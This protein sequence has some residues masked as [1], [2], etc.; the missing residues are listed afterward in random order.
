[1]GRKVGYLFKN[2]SDL[3]NTKKANRIT[4]GIN[5]AGA[6]VP[7]IRGKRTA[8]AKVVSLVADTDGKQ[9]ICVEVVPDATTGDYAVPTGTAWNFDTDNLSN[10][11]T[12]TNVLS[13]V[14]LAVDEVVEVEAYIDKSEDFQWLAKKQ[15][16]GTTTVYIE[17]TATTNISTYTGTIFDNPIDRTSVEVGV[18]VRSLKQS[19]GTIPNSAAG[20]GEWCRYD[21]DNDV[22]HVINPPIAYG[23]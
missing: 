22:Y 8:F 19:D 17:I 5:T 6:Q 4:L 13:M 1:M 3:D 18:T 15:G 10:E 2:E 11:Y 12:T 14:A 16:G 20:Q 21:S 23:A 9:A 7:L